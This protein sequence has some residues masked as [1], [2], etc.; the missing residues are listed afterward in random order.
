MHCWWNC[1]L[2][3][4]LWRTLWRFLKKL[5]ETHH[6]FSVWVS[7]SNY[8]HWMYVLSQLWFAF[9]DCGHHHVTHPSSR[10]SIQSFIDCLHR[11]DIQI[12]GSRV[13]STVDHGSSRKTQ[14][15]PEFHTLLRHLECRKGTKSIILDTRVPTSSV[16]LLSFSIF[17]SSNTIFLPIISKILNLQPRPFSGLIPN[18]W[19]SLVVQWLRLDASTAGGISSIPGW[20]TKIL[21]ASRFG[22]KEK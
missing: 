4:P 6:L 19:N 2:A 9:L 12:F 5:K 1:K 10:K 15:N 7:L 14:G 8:H 17:T 13:V 18:W 22:K 21:H 16:V 11:D 20:G 3:Q